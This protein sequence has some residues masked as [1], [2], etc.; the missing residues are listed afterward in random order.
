MLLP[1]NGLPVLQ[2]GEP[3]ERLAL[4]GAA[5]AGQRDRRA[6]RFANDQFLDVRL[7]ELVAIM[8][9]DPARVRVGQRQD[10]QL[11]DR[12]RDRSARRRS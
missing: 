3:R 8:A 7:G 2:R 1:A 11:D 10:G 12:A 4:D 5:D 6:D 9:A